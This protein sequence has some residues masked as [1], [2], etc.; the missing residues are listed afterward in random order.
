MVGSCHLL[1]SMAY[2][3]VVAARR[4]GPEVVEFLDADSGPGG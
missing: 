2:K 3:S 4:G 1:L